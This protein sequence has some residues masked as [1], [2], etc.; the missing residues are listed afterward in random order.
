MI[1]ID[2]VFVSEDVVQQKFACAIE[3]C[4]G[5]CCWEGDFGAPLEEDEIEIIEQIYPKIKARLSKEAIEVIESTGKYDLFGKP[6]FKGT[7]LLKDGSCVFLQYKAGI[8]SCAFER[9]Y[10]EGKTDWRKPISCHLYPIRVEKN[11]LTGFESLQYD[12]W[13]ICS[14]ACAKG[15]KE[16]IPLYQFVKAALIRKYGAEWYEQLDQLAKAQ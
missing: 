8:A 12:I 9:A 7:P 1:I 15:I 2:D 6:R 16:K 13:E 14:A 4:K 3:K 5:A 10:E 11:D